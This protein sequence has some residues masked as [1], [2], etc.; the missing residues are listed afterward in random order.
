MKRFTLWQKAALV[1]GG[2]G[3]AWAALLLLATVV[4]LKRDEGAAYP[5]GEPERAFEHVQSVNRDLLGPL[6]DRMDDH[7]T[8]GERWY[9]ED[10]VL[11]RGVGPRNGAT[12]PV[13]MTLTVGSQVFAGKAVIDVWSG[14]GYGTGGLDSVHSFTNGANLRLVERLPPPKPRPIPPGWRVI[15][16]GECV[17]ESLGPQDGFGVIGT[18]LIDLPKG[19]SVRVSWWTDLAGEHVPIVHSLAFE[20]KDIRARNTGS[21][22]RAER[23]RTEQDGRYELTVRRTDGPDAPRAAR[24]GNSRYTVYVTWGKGIRSACRPPSDFGNCFAEV[25]Q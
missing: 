21:G 25:R 11:I 9:D 20:G 4:T 13:W 2:V 18:F 14:L 17:L 7:W 1:A 6:H 16:P 8:C 12:V 5:K 3:W 19:K 23:Y 22:D 24:D 10:M 15:R